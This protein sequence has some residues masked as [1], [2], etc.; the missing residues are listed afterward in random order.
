VVTIRAVEQGETREFRP[1]TP[2]IS[3]LGWFPDARA[4]VA[5]VTDPRRGGRELVR[6]DLATGKITPLVRPFR[7]LPVFS[8]DGRTMYYMTS[9]A[10]GRAL[11]KTDASQLVARELPS[12]TEKVL[13]TPPEGYV[14]FGSD[15]VSP[16]YTLT[17]D[18]RSIVFPIADGERR[19]TEMRMISVPV[20][21]G[22]AR[23]LFV[24][25]PGD[26]L[27]GFRILGLSP[28]GQNVLFFRGGRQFSL[29]QVPVAGG[30]ATQIAPARPE[31]WS[32]V[33]SPNAR[34]I[35]FPRSTFDST[36]LWV[37]RDAALGG[38]SA[39]SGPTLRH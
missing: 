17:A 35:I 15:A 20:D 12:G 39:E 7:G 3:A 9:T 25:A 24:P 4:L 33:L 31:F 36:E 6:L 29:W 14:V 13:Y 23:E 27:P 34:R 1:A 18:G 32:T 37:L 38:G 22:P 5:R 16:L 8:S 10:L 19:F 28:D 2:Y 11:Q 26:S 30:S 21:G